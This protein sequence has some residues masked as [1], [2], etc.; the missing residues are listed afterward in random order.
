MMMNKTL[1]QQAGF[2]LIAAGALFCIVG[3]AAAAETK[4]TT[5]KISHPVDDS[6]SLVY[7]YDSVGEGGSRGKFS[8]TI[9][10]AG[11][12]NVVYA[13]EGLNPPGCGS[14]PALTELPSFQDKDANLVL[15]CGSGGQHQVMKAARVRNLSVARCEAS[16][17]FE[18][19]APNL[20][21][22]GGGKY[23]SKLSRRIALDT[24]FG[25][26]GYAAQ[27]Y[28]MAYFLDETP[29]TGCPRFRA[30]FGKEVEKYYTEDFSKRKG[31]G[32]KDQSVTGPMIA[33]LLATQNKKTI[34]AEI[35]ALKN[36]ELTPVKLKA[37]AESLRKIGYPFFD[38][39]QC[40]KS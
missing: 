30:A 27:D 17:D 4:P 16:L 19:S 1:L 36:P 6:K 10:S 23:L 9:K 5:Y 11:G 18:M 25:K 2:G 31:S 33:D 12:D 24:S 37:V 7:A 14:F 20:S 13:D 3:G 34:C 38:F 22:M 8:V 40:G 15:Y 35:R 39:A 32:K 28:F 21:E 29:T 26:S